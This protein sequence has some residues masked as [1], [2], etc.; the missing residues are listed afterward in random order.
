MNTYETPFSSELDLPVA[1]LDINTVCEAMLVTDTDRDDFEDMRQIMTGPVEAEVLTEVNYDLH[2]LIKNHNLG[3]IGLNE[4]NRQL[5]TVAE[6]S[7]A[8]SQDRLREYIEEANNL[9]SRRPGQFLFVSDG[10]SKWGYWFGM[11][12][13]GDTAVAALVIDGQLVYESLAD[14]QLYIDTAKLPPVEQA[15]LAAYRKIMEF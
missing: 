9:A 10:L 12:Q 1:A 8:S 6:R 11:S 7:L 14:Y 13:L 4:I 2:R 15:A 3:S 5:E